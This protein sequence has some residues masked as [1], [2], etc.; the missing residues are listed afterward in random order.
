MVNEN[1]K[2][3][4]KEIEF[5]RQNTD[6]PVCKQTIDE[7][8]RE[9]EISEKQKRKQ[10]LMMRLQKLLKNCNCQLSQFRDGETQKSITDFQVNYKTYCIYFCNQSV[11]TKVNEEIQTLNEKG[12]DVTDASK[13][14]KIKV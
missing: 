7:D 3:V 2:K 11:H 13:K 4:E 10:N 1:L 5:Y 9:C 12:A 14:L 6:C 8:H